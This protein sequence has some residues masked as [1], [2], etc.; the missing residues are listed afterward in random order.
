MLVVFPLGLLVTAVLFDIVYL[1]TSDTT[2][3]AVS[4]WCIVAGVVGGLLAA[5]PGLI[6]LVNIPGSTG[7][8]SLL[9]GTQSEIWP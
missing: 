8:A 6:D 3:A 1:V 5:F 4:F 9:A 7:R 2:F